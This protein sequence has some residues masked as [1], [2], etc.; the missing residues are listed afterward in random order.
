MSHFLRGVSR[1]GALIGFAIASGAG[2]FVFT[3][4]FR[5]VAMGE[6]RT[7]AKSPSH[8]AGRSTSRFAEIGAAIFLLLFVTSEAV[9]AV[10]ALR[11]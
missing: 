5:S 11:R 1:L 8:I 7:D 10:V 2:C 9:A 3:S 6:E 4:G